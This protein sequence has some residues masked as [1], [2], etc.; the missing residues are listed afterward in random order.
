MTQSMAAIIWALGLLIWWAIR[1]PRRRAAKRAAVAL[2]K[3][4]T[5]ERVALG[6]CILGLVILPAIHLLA[7]SLFGTSPFGFADYPFQPAIAIL[8]VLILILCLYLFWLSH[9]HLGK[10]WS[11]TLELRE[12][13]GLIRHGLYKYV[14]HPMY[15]SFFLWGIAQFLLLP[16]WVAGLVGFVSVAWLYFSR[17]DQEEA[18]MREQFSEEYNEYCQSTPRIFPKLF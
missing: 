5:G 3:K 6:L 4:S 12:N 17:I 2:D 11:V 13:H 10:N 18:M 16:N 8:G 1:I 15:S 9:H 14:R 7:K